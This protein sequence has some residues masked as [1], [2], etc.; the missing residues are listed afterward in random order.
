MQNTYKYIDLSGYSFTGKGAY[1][2]LFSEFSTFHTHPYGFEFLSKAYGH[3]PFHL[4]SIKLFIYFS[5][6]VLKPGKT[7][8]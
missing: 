8:S 4:E 7:Y 6:I 5:D 1:N 2:H 3:C